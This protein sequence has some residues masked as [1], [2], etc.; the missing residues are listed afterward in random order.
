M[1]NIYPVFQPPVYS[2]NW[3][4]GEFYLFLSGIA[5]FTQG[6]LRSVK[7]RRRRTLPHPYIIYMSCIVILFDLQYTIAADIILSRVI[8]KPDYAV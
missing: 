5:V 3:E 2:F 8:I 4:R 6:I 7:N 1:R